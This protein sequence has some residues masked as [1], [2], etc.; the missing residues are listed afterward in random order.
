MAEE[1][2]EHQ[3]CPYRLRAVPGKL[4]LSAHESTYRGSIA[5]RGNPAVPGEQEVSYHT[6]QVLREPPCNRNFE[7]PLGRLYEVGR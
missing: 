2:L 4:V 3:D 7:A 1:E 6:A 5:E